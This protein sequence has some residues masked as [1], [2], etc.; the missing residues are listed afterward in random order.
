MWSDDTVNFETK[1]NQDYPG[2]YIGYIAWEAVI[3]KYTTFCLWTLKY[4]LQS[5]FIQ[6]E[7]TV[8]TAHCNYWITHILTCA[9]HV[10]D[11]DVNKCKLY[12]VRKV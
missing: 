11:G 1:T 6:C 8:A 10:I 12:S 2:I 4:A 5:I 3:L 9:L 7:T